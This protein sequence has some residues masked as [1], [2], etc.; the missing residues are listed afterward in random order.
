[1][2]ERK[3]DDLVPLLRRVADALERLAPAAPP[4]AGLDSAEA[5]L[6]E[7]EELQFASRGTTQAITLFRRLVE[8]YDR[9]GRDSEAARYREVLA[10]LGGPL[11]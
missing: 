7:W 4:S 8:V 10:G 5:L 9:Q 11:G 1:M 6:R 3:T 2:T